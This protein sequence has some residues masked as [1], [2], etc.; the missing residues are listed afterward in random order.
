M[1]RALLPA[2]SAAALLAGCGSPSTMPMKA[3]LSG[4]SVTL[5]PGIVPGGEAQAP[6]GFRPT[7]S[8]IVS[9]VPA[10]KGKEAP[11]LKVWSI[12]VESQR[13]FASGAAPTDPSVGGQALKLLGQSFIGEGALLQF[14]A[15]WE[16]P[17]E[18]H[19]IAVEVWKDGRKL[20]STASTIEIHYLPASRPRDRER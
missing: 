13:A 17:A 6:N 7:L 20:A 19:F 16:G 2:L 14:D 1:N 12:P 15:L 3:D 18:G 8:A 4:A 9:L 11:E 10:Y 5:G